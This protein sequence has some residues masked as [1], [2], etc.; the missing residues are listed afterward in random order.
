[1]INAKFK[2]TG[3]E[4]SSLKRLVVVAQKQG[5]IFYFLVT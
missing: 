2:G 1:M 5:S 3:T 4:V